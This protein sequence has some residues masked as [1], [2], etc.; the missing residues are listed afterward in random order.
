MDAVKTCS[1]DPSM[2][3]RLAFPFPLQRTDHWKCFPLNWT[4]GVFLSQQILSDLL[5]SFC[6]YIRFPT[7][8]AFVCFLIKRTLENTWSFLYMYSIATGP[9]SNICK[10]WP[11]LLWISL[12]RLLSSLVECFL[13]VNITVKTTYIFCIKFNNYHNTTKN[14]A[15]TLLKLNEWRKAL[16][17]CCS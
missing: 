5:S 4:R 12:C 10:Q 15:F 3:W 2:T 14:S 17:W 9:I 8:V 16:A 7:K 11:G 6:F 1:L 13:T